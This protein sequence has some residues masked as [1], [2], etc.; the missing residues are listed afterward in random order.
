MKDRRAAAAIRIRLSYDWII[1]L[2]CLFC[3][4]TQIICKG[5]SGVFPY[6]VGACVFIEVFCVWT[7]RKLQTGGEA[8]HMPS[9]Q[10]LTQESSVG[11]IVFCMVFDFAILAAFTL[12]FLVRALRQCAI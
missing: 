10:T 5:D 1:H 7:Y 4:L 6:V 11:A 8:Y 9:Y 12:P 3:F 2:Y